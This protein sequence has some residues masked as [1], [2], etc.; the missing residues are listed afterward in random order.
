MIRERFGAGTLYQ[1]PVVVHAD[2]LDSA[3]PTF[4]AAIERLTA[5][6]SAAP[7]VSRVETAW[8]TPRAELLG[9]DG[10]SAL[11]LV[12]RA[13]LPVLSDL[14]GDSRSGQVLGLHP[15]LS[16]AMLLPAEQR[17]ARDAP[18]ELRTALARV[19]SSDGRVGV[20]ALVTRVR[21]ATAAQNWRRHSDSNRRA[22]G[23]WRIRRAYRRVRRHGC[24]VAG[25]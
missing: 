14:Q 10:R 22:G 18:E 7:S 12:T 5:S 2:S 15:P 13:L 3:D 20:V 1:F 16:L 4:R 19:L 25:E 6:L 24:V 9:E 11:L 17:N 23:N 21:E 8:N